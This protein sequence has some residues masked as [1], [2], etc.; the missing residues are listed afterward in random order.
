MA[1]LEWVSAA[2]DLLKDPVFAKLERTEAIQRIQARMEK[3]GIKLKPDAQDFDAIYIRALVEYGF[4]RPEIVLNLWREEIIQEAFKK[5]FYENDPSIVSNEVKNMEMIFEEKGLLKDADYSLVKEINEFELQFYTVIDEIRTV[6]DVTQDAKIAQ[7]RQDFYLEIDSLSGAIDSIRELAEAPV[8]PIRELVIPPPIYLPKHYV[9][10]ISYQN[11][12]VTTIGIN[13]IKSAL[14]K[15][16]TIVVLS[17]IGGSGKSTL[18]RSICADPKFLNRFPGGVIWINLRD[19][20]RPVTDIFSELLHRA[21]IDNLSHHNTQILTQIIR[22]I[23]SSKP[24]LIVLDDT[25]S[26]EYVQ[27]FKDCLST[28]SSMLITTRDLELSTRISANKEVQIQGFTHN[29]AKKAIEII[30]GHNIKDKEW[31]DSVLPL[32]ESLGFHPLAV[33][34]SA[35][36]ISLGASSWNDLLNSIRTGGISKALD[37]SKPKLANESLRLSFLRTLNKIESKYLNQLKWLSVLSIGKPFYLSDGAMILS[38]MKEQQGQFKGVQGEFGIEPDPE[39]I[40]E[41]KNQAREVLSILA[42][43]GVVQVLEGLRGLDIYYIHPIIHAL[44]FEQLKETDEFHDALLHHAHVYSTLMIT[45]WKTPA[46]FHIYKYS[47]NQILELLERAWTRLNQ[48]EGISLPSNKVSEIVITSLAVSLSKQWGITGEYHTA[49]KWLTRALSILLVKDDSKELDIIHQIRTDLGHVHFHLGELAQA[50]YHFS[51]AMRISEIT[52]D[53]NEIIYD[54]V[55]Q[56][57][58]LI[59]NSK[60]REAI[61]LLRNSL[62]KARNLKDNSLIGMVLGTLA[63]AYIYTGDLDA[64]VILEREALTLALKTNN[65]RAFGSRSGNLGS[66]LHSRAIRDFTAAIQLYHRSRIFALRNGNVQSQ[67][68]HL[69]NLSRAYLAIGAND[70]AR[71][72]LTESIKLFNQIGSP[73]VSTA[74]IILEDIDERR[75]IPGDMLDMN[76]IFDFAEAAIEGDLISLERIKRFSALVHRN[77]EKMPDIAKIMDRVLLVIDGE[78]DPSKLVDDLEDKNSYHLRL[79]LLNLEK[80]G[81]HFFLLPFIITVTKAIEG[82][83]E[84]IENARELLKFLE[85]QDPLPGESYGLQFLVRNLIAGETDPSFLTSE[86]KNDF[87]R[88]T[89]RVLISAGTPEFRLPTPGSLET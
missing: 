23:L 73:L 82:N 16:P 31:N 45:E 53:E 64:A 21:G 74:Q 14:N 36:Q 72:A 62:N 11:E 10:R 59:A 69:M 5:S 56:G 80:P 4:N 83:E 79:L 58:I 63:H 28:G 32:I 60:H 49:K 39:W 34:L 52:N 35:S 86:I 61:D 78:R 51:N 75:I 77:Q 12:I 27:A 9:E 76:E 37:F 19:E 22:S 13:Q 41:Q 24:T 44:L 81:V 55:N 85:V 15:P 71:L 29:E 40:K 48:G 43:Y 54:E 30:I 57:N 47:Y 7:L 70:L 18:A 65:L 17:G 33:S 25:Q 20:I 42:N 46:K 66:M 84:E 50:E 68:N 88:E 67:A 6:V 8:N 1:I 87:L 2:I 89:L 26:A 38:G 3:I